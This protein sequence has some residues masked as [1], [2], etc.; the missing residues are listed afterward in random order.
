VELLDTS[1]LST[2]HQSV[3]TPSI[4]QSTTSHFLDDGFVREVPVGPKKRS[5]KQLNRRQ[6]VD[7]YF[8]TGN[9]ADWECD[10]Y[11]PNLQ[12]IVFQIEANGIARD[13]DK[14]A[15]Y[16]T[17]FSDEEVGQFGILTNWMKIRMR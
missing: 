15:V 6:F 10:K 5:T 8:A 1:S 3:T 16:Y 2:Q 17:G 13:D 9:Q 7:K 12:H 14:Y 4:L 11:L